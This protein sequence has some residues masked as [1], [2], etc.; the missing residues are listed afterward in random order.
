MDGDCNDNAAPSLTLDQAA[1][2]LSC[3]EKIADILPEL[4]CLLPL[5]KAMP[6]GKTEAA[7][8]LP[9]GRKKR[10]KSTS[11]MELRR[12]L[13]QELLNRIDPNFKIGGG[14]E[15]SILAAH[16]LLL[17]WYEDFLNSPLKDFPCEPPRG[18]EKDMRYFDVFWKMSRQNNRLFFSYSTFKSLAKKRFATKW[19]LPISGK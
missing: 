19:G 2:A 11:P 7:K 14:G 18:R 12:A 5:M 8:Y 15:M 13:H 17:G 1:S 4:A 10:D 9:D 6:L 16:Q 3:I